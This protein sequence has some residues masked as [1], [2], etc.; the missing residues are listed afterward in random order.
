MS[1][2]CDLRCDRQGICI[3]LLAEAGLS[4]VRLAACGRPRLDSQHSWV[5][6]APG[7]RPSKRCIPCA[8]SVTQKLAKKAKLLTAGWVAIQ[9]PHQRARLLRTVR[10]RRKPLGPKLGRFALRGRS[11]ADRSS[12]IC[13]PSTRSNGRPAA[14]QVGKRGINR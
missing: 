11:R 14:V 4:R 13:G 10:Y 3:Q 5:A 2:N 12:A 7:N 9:C 1:G 8:H 6:I